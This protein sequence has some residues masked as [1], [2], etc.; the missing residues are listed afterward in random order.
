MPDE[1][2]T[3]KADL[4]SDSFVVEWVSA[5]Y[6]VVLAQRVNSKKGGSAALTS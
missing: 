1:P 3:G 6:P 4:E 2:K 5:P